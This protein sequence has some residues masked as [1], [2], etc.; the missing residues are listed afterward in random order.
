MD[1]PRQGCRD[2]EEHCRL[3]NPVY[4]LFNVEAHARWFITQNT[5]ERTAVALTQLLSQHGCASI[6]RVTHSATPS[7]RRKAATL[8][9]RGVAIPAVGLP[10]ALVIH[11]ALECQ[12]TTTTWSRRASEADHGQWIAVIGCEST[13]LNPDRAAPS[14]SELAWRPAE[15]QTIK[16]SIHYLVVGVLS[17]VQPSPFRRKSDR[18]TRHR[19]FAAARGP[20]QPDR[21]R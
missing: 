18:Q 9:P 11:E 21:L 15:P 8:A 20:M 2:T 13:N 12:R 5:S 10:N 14:G 1:G 17:S 4:R 6:S 3:G 19:P 16:L 7:L